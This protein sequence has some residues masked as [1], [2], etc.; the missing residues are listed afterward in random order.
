MDLTLVH[1][2]PTDAPAGASGP[3]E[4]CR[5]VGA[6][7]SLAGAFEMGTGFDCFDTWSHTAATGIPAQA[8]E[9][10]QVLLRHMTAAGFAN[11]RREWWHFTLS[12]SG[13][14]VTHDFPVQ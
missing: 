13:F 5:A 11:Y 8:K 10:R 1:V 2:R 3:V 12:V 9:N 4:T 14:E 7:R 6:D